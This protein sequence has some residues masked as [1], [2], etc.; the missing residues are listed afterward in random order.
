MPTNGWGAILVLV[1]VPLLATCGDAPDPG[2]AGNATP[3]ADPP[4]ADA[5][6]D[7]GADTGTSSRAVDSPADPPGATADT[8]AREDSLRGALESL[9]A[10][11][12][13]E[14]RAAGVDSWFSHTTADVLRGVEVDGGRVV[15]DLDQDLA[16]LIPNAST[17]AGSA[18][19]LAQLDSVV[20]RFP[21]VEAVEYR[22]GGS[23]DA[24]WEWLQRACGTVTR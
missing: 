22:M 5:R 1:L 17:S 4:A 10:G 7:T 9:L 23:C 8:A 19:L 18:M 15:V 6:R 20:F 13:A 16:E 2:P 3:A 21:W 11:P 14:Q 24:F 12:S